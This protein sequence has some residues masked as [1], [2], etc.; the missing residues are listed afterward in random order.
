M[1]DVFSIVGSKLKQIEDVTNNVWRKED[2]ILFFFFF[3]FYLDLLE[4]ETVLEIF[5]AFT[6]ML[7]LCVIINKNTIMNRTVKFLKKD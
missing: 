2:P 7:V 1:T 5:G 4:T 6:A 3:F